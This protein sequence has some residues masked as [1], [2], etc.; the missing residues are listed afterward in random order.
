MHREVLIPYLEGALREQLGL[1]CACLIVISTL[2]MC[3][4]I[5]VPYLKVHACEW[6]RFDRACF[7]V[8]S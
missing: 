4:K 6:L 7:I 8:R 5:L 3:E 2:F 1:N